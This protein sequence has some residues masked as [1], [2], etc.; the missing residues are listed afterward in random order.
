MSR[1]EALSVYADLGYPD[2]PVMERKAQLVV[3]I[4]AELQSRRINRRAAAGLLGMEEPLLRNILGGRFRLI[5]IDE[6]N[7]M[8]RVLR[9]S[10]PLAPGSIKVRRYTRRQRKRHHVSEFAQTGVDLA[11]TFK[12]EVD[13]DSVID[14]FIADVHA[15]GLEAAGFGGKAPCLSLEGA[16]VFC[17]H[18]QDAIP[19]IEQLMIRLRAWPDVASVQASSIW[20]GWWSRQG[21]E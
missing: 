2:A 11:I 15:L 8:A 7:R 14:E 21:D 4:A 20:D 1:N 9:E 18:R 12:H 17:G 3:E 10:L 16:V 6:L 5:G 19:A 13:W